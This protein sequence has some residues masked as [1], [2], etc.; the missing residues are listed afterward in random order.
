MSC[1]QVELVINKIHGAAAT[2]TVVDMT[3]LLSKFTNDIV[4]RAVAGRSFR[5]EGRD[6]VFRELIDQGTALVAGFNLENLYP[7]LAKA[8]GGVLVSPAR[9]KAER[10]RDTWDMLLDKLIDEHASEIAAAATRLEDAGGNDREYDFIHVLLSVQH[11]YGL[12]RE[13]IKGILEVS[14]PI[15]LIS[16]LSLPEAGRE[17]RRHIFLEIYS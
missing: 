15:P 4:C 10:L 1:V 16:L 6:R 12:T 17:E 5:V 8:A 7:G 9:R 13:S 3:E 11:E 2:R 14:L